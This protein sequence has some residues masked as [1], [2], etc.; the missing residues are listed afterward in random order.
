[1]NRFFLYY[2]DQLWGF[3]N[4]DVK[5]FNPEQSDCRQWAQIR[6]AAGMK[7]IIIMVCNLEKLTFHL[8][9]DLALNSGI[10][11]LTWQ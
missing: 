11:K 6:K 4:E 2:T 1:M 10:N 7:G 9:Q 5:L 3:G 8:Y